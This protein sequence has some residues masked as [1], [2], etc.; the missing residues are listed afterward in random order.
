VEPKLKK[1]VE[2]I[3][4]DVTLNIKEHQQ[5]FFLLCAIEYADLSI[6]NPDAV[7]REDSINNEIFLI[8]AVSYIK[9]S[10]LNPIR[11][12]KE[13]E[14]IRQNEFENVTRLRILYPSKL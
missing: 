10:M 1:A 11:D 8:K 5:K 13:I 3:L 4:R 7:T 6:F 14:W 2:A 12:I 9:R